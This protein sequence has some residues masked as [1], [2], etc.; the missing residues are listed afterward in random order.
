[1]LVT[2]D[3]DGTL[4]GARGP[5]GNSAHKRAIDDA[6]RAVYG[7]SVT[8]NEVPHA[9]STDRAIIRDMCLVGG[10]PAADIAA[11]MHEAIAEADKRIVGYVDED[12]SH[13]VLPGVREA[14]LRLQELGVSLALTTGNLESCAW[15]K[16]EAAGLKGFFETGG[17]GSDCLLRT[18]ILKTAVERVQEKNPTFV[19]KNG[20]GRRLENVFHVGD[21]VADMQAARE[22]GA[23]GIGVLTGSFSRDQLE[24][25]DPVAVLMD[26]SDTDG[27]LQL[28]GLQET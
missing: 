27:F 5:S 11:R 20:S 9:G 19:A 28:L 21:A 18:D 13:L 10:V 2:W 8:V 24:A 22:N 25:E 6:V 3:I 23:G 1:M 12:L 4:L 7:I 15:E 16:V 17:F 14:L 26:L